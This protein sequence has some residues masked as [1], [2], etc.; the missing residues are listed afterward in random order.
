V[1]GGFDAHTAFGALFGT[2]GHG[3][4]DGGEEGGVEWGEM[5]HLGAGP[6]G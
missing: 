4:H 2:L 5:S 1:V 6:V 3:Q